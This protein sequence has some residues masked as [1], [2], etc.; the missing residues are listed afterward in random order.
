MILEKKVQRQIAFHEIKF[1]L[2]TCLV[3]LSLQR[4]FTISSIKSFGRQDQ[5]RAFPIYYFLISNR[6]FDL[7]T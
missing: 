5:S 4:L 2:I 7:S 1:G 3:K 6:L